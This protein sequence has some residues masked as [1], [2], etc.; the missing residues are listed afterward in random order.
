[1]MKLKLVNEDRLKVLEA[2]GRQFDSIKKIMDK[3][4]KPQGI[5]TGFQVFQ[6]DY[7]IPFQMC[8]G[9]LSGVKV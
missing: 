6:R 1:M 8:E 2:K 5:L 7:L 9:I 3:A 4:M